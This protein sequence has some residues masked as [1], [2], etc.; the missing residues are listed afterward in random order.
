MHNI[1]L[2]LTLTGGLVAALLFGYGTHRLGLSPIVG[3]LLA[4]IVVGPNTPGFVANRSL[5]D[6]L[7]EVGVILL[8]FGVGL[9]FHFE[10]LLAVRRV[11]VPGALGQSL[12][13]TVLGCL[14]AVVVGWGWSAGLVFGLAISVASTVVLLRVLADNND[15][16]TPT[17]HIAVG[18]LVVEDLFTVLVLVL[19]PDVVRPDSAGAGGVVLALGW[20][21]V[22]IGLLV[23]FV[24]VG[25][26]RV[27]PWLLARVAATHSRELFT[28]TI[29]AV[30]LGIA[31]GSAELF[32][33]SMALGAFLAGM[34]VGRS[35]FSSR[36][37]SEAL[38]MR[39]AFAVLFFVSVGMLFNPAYL[40]EAP[41][42]VAVTLGIVLL[43]KPL[44][45]LAIVLLLKYPLRV[46]LAVAVALAQIGEFSFI[47]AALGRELG[48]LPVSANNAL[49]AAAIVSISINPALYRLTDALERRAKRSP[50]L[51]RWLSARSRVEP[52][53]RPPAPPGR[54][55]APHGR[56]VVVGYG[57]VGR[58]LV[59]LLQESEVEP[60]VIE[61]NLD[62]VRRLREDGLR[63]V[64][65]DATHRET[66]EEAGARHAAVYILSSSGMH[67]SQE[68]I[69]LA[70][71]INPRIRVFARASYL[72][73]IPALRR[74][75]A[76]A[77]F[78]GEG[79]VALSMT[80]FIL[81]RLGASGEQIDRERD[82]LRE[83]L[84]GSLLA[85]EVLLPPPGRP[86][87]DDAPAPEP[88]PPS[89]NG[90][91]PAGAARGAG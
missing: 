58:T 72:R 83:E 42:L 87:A 12:V 71:E 35:E 30:A 17:G 77:V 74:A 10:D 38:P 65:G 44:A 75:G 48:I 34:V 73:E 89:G 81:R 64:Y 25:G 51:W 84:F 33:V 85:I 29:L 70:R 40:V 4:G 7:A 79:E 32:G 21:V 19:L 2:I 14:V 54:D 66:V 46:A 82:R 61:L 49:V 43:G 86:A 5:A 88:A 31:V 55:P 80:E 60:T 6:Q 28:L 63:A 22:K 69:R 52:Q 57:P 3:Y 53:G 68:A 15:L 91:P 62:T 27:L 24:G 67:A 16:H 8:M 47:L 41:G 11:A 18:W 76:D 26:G 36:A 56:A 78:T 59:R 45:A 20:S 1:E 50:R 23:A 9:H 39:D 13:A 37:A 90:E